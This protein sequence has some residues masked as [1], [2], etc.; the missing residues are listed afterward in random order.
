L[1]ITFDPKTKKWEF[2][3]KN[4]QEAQAVYEIGKRA[5]L[6]GVSVEHTAKLFNGWLTDKDLPMFNA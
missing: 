1:P 6:T 3:P 2:K 4:P 5:I